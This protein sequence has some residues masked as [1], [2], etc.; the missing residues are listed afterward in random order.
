MAEAVVD[1]LEAIEIEKE[2]GEASGI[3]LLEVW[4][5][6][7]N[8]LQ[9]HRAVREPGELIAPDRAAV[10]R[11]RRGLFG[12]VVERSGDDL[13]PVIDASGR[14]RPTEK[15][16]ISAVFVAEAMLVQ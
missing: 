13:D 2:H 6:S 11:L 7:A 8:R 10:S 14:D 4:Q 9:E 15:P 16:A 1:H 3:V 5:P 12:N